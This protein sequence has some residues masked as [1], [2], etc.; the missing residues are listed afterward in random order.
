V[1]GGKRGGGTGDAEK[2]G[3]VV[4]GGSWETG[5]LEGGVGPGR[6]AGERDTESI[7]WGLPLRGGNR[8]L[9]PEK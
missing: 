4:T 5:C 3:G 1:L 9:A 2:P 8:T 7:G 6:R